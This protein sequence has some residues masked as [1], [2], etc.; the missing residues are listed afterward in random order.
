MIVKPHEIIWR[1]QYF[2]NTRT[3]LLS[4]FAD[5]KTFAGRRLRSVTLSGQSHRGDATVTF[6]V[7]EDCAT[8]ILPN[9]ATSLEWP[10]GKVIAGPIQDWRFVL[11]GDLYVEK[12]DLELVPGTLGTLK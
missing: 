1:H 4:N 5:F 9:K 8:A 7:G 12:I 3:F 11:Q 10:V 6:C 2:A